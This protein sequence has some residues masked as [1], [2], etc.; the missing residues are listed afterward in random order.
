MYQ[1][2]E[3]SVCRRSIMKMIGACKVYMVSTYVLYRALLI[4]SDKFSTELVSKYVFIFCNDA[5]R[6]VCATHA[7][8][9][10]CS[11]NEKCVGEVTSNQTF[12]VQY[13]AS[14]FYESSFSINCKFIIGCR[15]IT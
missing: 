9:I 12:S 4:G 6:S 5:H 10:I 7:A 1:S 8:T 2:G 14:C 13:I 3:S 15:V 11:L